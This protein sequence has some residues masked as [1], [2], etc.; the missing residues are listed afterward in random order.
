MTLSSSN[1][2]TKL[3][4]CST[5]SNS[6]SSSF[7]SSAISPSV[8]LLSAEKK[9]VKSLSEQRGDN[10]PRSKIDREKSQFSLI[11]Y[12]NQISQHMHLQV[13]T[14]NHVAGQNI[15]E[16]RKAFQNQI[17]SKGEAVIYMEP[18][19]LVMSRSGKQNDDVEC[20]QWVLEQNDDVECYQWVLEQNDDV[21]CYQWVL[22]QNDDVECY[23]WVLEQ[24]DDVECYQWV[25]EQNDDVECYQW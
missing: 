3:F 4:L 22:E 8:L 23:Q 9:F 20:Y 17:V 2:A 16:V 18:E 15:V 13:A 21:E 10:Q 6:S 19:K 1:M 5:T 11:M 25:L 7:P 12:C 24:N 14:L